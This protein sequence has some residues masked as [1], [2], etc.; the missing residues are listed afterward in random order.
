M[1]Q[2]WCGSCGISLDSEHHDTQ[3]GTQDTH[4]MVLSPALPE[5]PKEKPDPEGRRHG[6][7]R[8]KEVSFWPGLQPASHLVP[9]HKGK[10]LEY[11]VDQNQ[12]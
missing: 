12:D 11:A 5:N 4:D 1:N 10:S 6:S 7:P 3:D 2:P 9:G 8:E